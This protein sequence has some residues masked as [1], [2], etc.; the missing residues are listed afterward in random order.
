MRREHQAT[1]SRR[2]IARRADSRQ[3]VSLNPQGEPGAA[4]PGSSGRGAADG[5][6]R[7]RSQRCGLSHHTQYQFKHQLDG[8]DRPPSH[9]RPPCPG[10]HRPIPAAAAAAAPARQLGA[11]ALWRAAARDR[12]AAGRA[13]AA[14][15]AARAARHDA[16]AHI[17]PRP[18]APWQAAW[19]VPSCGHGT[20]WRRV[21]RAGTG[22]AARHALPAAA[23]PRHSIPSSAAAD[24]WQH[25]RRHAHAARN[26]NE[27]GSTQAAARAAPRNL[28]SAANDD[29]AAPTACSSRRPRAAQGLRNAN[30]APA[31]HA[32]AAVRRQAAAWPDARDDARRAAAWHAYATWHVC[33]HGA[34][35]AAG[36]AA[37]VQGRQPTR[38]D[39]NVLPCPPPRG[40]GSGAAHL[41]K[42]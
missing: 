26:A 31:A 8:E 21:C 32:P 38:Q 24:A 25:A 19:R 22:R 34:A 37:A 4:A 36:G 35:A 15:R 14:R 29:A 6:C 20:P 16:T 10:P 27:R 1:G 5:T 2:P 42:A 39:G 17:H 12:A 40:A 28:C 41:C 13:A 3:R 18:G 30:H 33:Q 23:A 7:R 11:A 9:S